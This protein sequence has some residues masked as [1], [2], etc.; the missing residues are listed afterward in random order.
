MT[1]TVAVTGGIGAGK[2][3]V[4]GLLAASGA[5]VVDSDRLAR[6]VVGV[7]TPGLAAVADEFGPRVLAADGSLDRGA[8]ASIVFSDASARRRLEAIT[9]PL[10]RAR[11]SELAAAAPRGSVVVND[12]PLLT[13]RAAAA[14]FHLVIGVGAPED[15]R[16]RRLIDRGLS[17]RDATARIASQIDDT[18]RRRL[19]DVWI[20]NSGLSSEARRQANLL[21]TRLAEYAANVE[22][23]GG[24]RRGRPELVPY[25]AEW[26]AQADRLIDRVRDAVG[27]LRV[28]HI[29][30]TAVPGFPATDVIDLQLGVGDMDQAAHLAPKLIAAGFPPLN[31]TVVDTPHGPDQVDSDSAG[32]R[33]IVHVNADP[34]RDLNLHLRV[35]NAP[36]WRWALRFRDWLRGDP[37]GRDDYLAVQRAAADTH[38][39]DQNSAGDTQAEE[40]FLVEADGRSRAWADRVGWQ[41]G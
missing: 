3:T 24:A 37:D 15:L 20:D 2:S 40:E 1:I 31:G 16:I 10:V 26:P 8:L 18:V 7:G 22:A 28:D 39:S 25:R 6:E 27:D 17:L 38:S 19:C 9:H 33:K 29:G 34:G 13:T 11:F 32:W 41:P 36:N 12:I 30:S 4:S 5:V 35:R 14:V 23:A 21:Y